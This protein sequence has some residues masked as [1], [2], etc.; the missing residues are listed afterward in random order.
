MT[1]DV[2]VQVDGT[3]TTLT[4]RGEVDLDN[5]EQVGEDLTVAISNQ[6]TTVCIDLRDVSFIDSAGLRTLF[7]LANRLDRLQIELELVAAPG[8]PARRVIDLSGLSA[9][10]TVLDD[11]G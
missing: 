10:A 1:A 6:A 2:E 5:H 8:A 4:V 7:A 3:T 11:L 9:L